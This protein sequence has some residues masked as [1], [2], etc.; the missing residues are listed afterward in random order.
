[1]K[2]V[3]GRFGAQ[4]AAA[5]QS[6]QTLQQRLD[7]LQAGDW[8]GQGATAFYQEM[9]GQVLPTLKRLAAAL[10]SAQQTTT[11]ISQVMAQAEADAARV[12]R[13]DGSTSG[14]AAA[15]APSPET[16]SFFGGAGGGTPAGSSQPAGPQAPGPGSGSGATARPQQIAVMLEQMV[17]NMG[18]I[19]AALGM[20][21][22]L[23]AAG[24]AGV[25]A[26]LANASPVIKAAV[27][28]ALEANP[29]PAVKA[30]GIKALEEQ[31]VDRKLA[32][33]SQPVRDLVKQSPT[34]RAEI[35]KAEEHGFTFY[36]LD[37]TRQ[38]VTDV[39]HHNVFVGTQ[40]LSDAAI[41]RH[42]AHEASHPASDQPALEPTAGVPR[43]QYIDQGVAAKLHGE[44]LAEFNA[45]QARADIL[46]AGGPDIGRNKPAGSDPYQSLYNDY[47]ASRITKD[48]GLNQM[49]TAMATE[50]PAPSRAAPSSRCTPICSGKSGTQSLAAQPPS[51]PLD[52]KRQ[53]GR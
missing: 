21:D 42:I 18:K 9:G 34:I 36:N 5:R 13:G 20:G 10:E 29:S 52:N 23:A 43:Q 25:V 11:Q 1:M 8:L 19:G 28:N 16:A 12:L 24:A 47:V 37:N 32:E 15:S 4:A 41:V 26:G 3:A 33:F 44:A 35:A 40:G 48:Q 30:A 45:V 2:S 46:A 27:I 38:F 50:I 6:L 49:A 17:E 22:Q 7:V 51:R 14:G 31:A 53:S 39:E